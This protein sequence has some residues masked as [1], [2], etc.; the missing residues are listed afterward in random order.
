MTYII[1]LILKHTSLWGLYMVTPQGLLMIWVWV[2]SGD[3]QD[4]NLGKKSKD[5][6]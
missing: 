1:T 5:S 2:S 6:P 4:E 3:T